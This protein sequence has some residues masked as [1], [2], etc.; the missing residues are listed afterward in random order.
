MAYLFL[1]PMRR[2]RS[3][4]DQKPWLAEAA[5]INRDRGWPGCGANRPRSLQPRKEHA[6]RASWMARLAVAYWKQQEP[7]LRAHPLT[8]LVRRRKQPTIRAAK[9]RLHKQRTTCY[10]VQANLERFPLKH[11]ES[12]RS[13]RLA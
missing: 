6:R 12:R 5:R 3:A 2:V 7:K 11:P 8:A 4:Q 9:N 1:A 13:R 10:N